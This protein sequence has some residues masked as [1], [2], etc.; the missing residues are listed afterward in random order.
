ANREGRRGGRVAEPERRRG[1]DQYRRRPRSQR[2]VYEGRFA[3]PGHARRA[4]LRARD[5]GSTGARG[6]LER[7]QRPPAARAARTEAV[8]RRRRGP[9]RR[10]SR[11]RVA[12]HDEK[13]ETKTASPF[14]LRGPGRARPRVAARGRDQT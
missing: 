12:P 1:A 13:G 14:E 9:A 7:R 6:G 10:V 11:V 3:R 2:L 8:V 4:D 5:P